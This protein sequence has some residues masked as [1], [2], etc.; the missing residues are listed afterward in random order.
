MTNIISN[1]SHWEKY[2]LYSYHFNITTIFY[3]NPIGVS[4]LTSN[5]SNANWIRIYSTENPKCKRLP[6]LHKSKYKSAK[7]G[8]VKITFSA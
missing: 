7:R 3:S 6:G 4:Y 1:T 2:T 5:N 8:Q